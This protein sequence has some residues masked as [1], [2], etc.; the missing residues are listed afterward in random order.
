[1]QRFYLLRQ[2]KF[3]SMSGDAL[4]N[5]FASLVLSRINYALPAVFAHN[6]SKDDTNKINALLR[7]SQKWG[8]NSKSYNLFELSEQANIQ[9]SIKMLSLAIAS[10]ILSPC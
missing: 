10:T 7:K 6:L 9:L 8:V 1:M 3:M 5:V 2:L 4:D